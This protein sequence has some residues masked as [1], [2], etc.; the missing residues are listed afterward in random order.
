MSLK[1]RKSEALNKKAST[2]FASL[3]QSVVAVPMSSDEQS[4]V[5]SSSRL[6]QTVME[7]TPQG[8]FP[9]FIKGY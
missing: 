2:K 6:N 5:A 3:N 4:M 7:Q 9:K 8:E 1:Q